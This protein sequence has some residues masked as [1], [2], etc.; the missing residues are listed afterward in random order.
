M[1]LDSTAATGA[2]QNFHETVLHNKWK[3]RKKNIHISTESFLGKPEKE[4]NGINDKVKDTYQ[5]KLPRTQSPFTWDLKGEIDYKAN[6][7]TSGWM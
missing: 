7:Y 6:K 4:K 1:K 3:T 5:K 2:T